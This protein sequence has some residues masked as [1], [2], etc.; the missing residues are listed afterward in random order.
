MGCNALIACVFTILRRLA[1]YHANTYI[2]Y[3]WLKCRKKF[4]ITLSYLWPIW[5]NNDVLTRYPCGDARR[6]KNLWFPI[7]ALFSVWALRHTF[8]HCE[9]ILIARTKT[10]LDFESWG[11]FSS[12]H[13]YLNSHIIVFTSPWV[14]SQ[15]ILT[16]FCRQ[17]SFLLYFFVD[18]F[19]TRSSAFFSITLEPRCLDI[20]PW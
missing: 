7:M 1:D 4:K 17:F 19:F 20:G 11:F 18:L 5:Q 10:M 9:F 6:D 8:G 14:L 2:L 3:A 12:E 15:S 13:M 16:H